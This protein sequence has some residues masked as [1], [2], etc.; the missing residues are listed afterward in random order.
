M[1]ASGTRGGPER[2]NVRSR[3]TPPIETCATRTRTLANPPPVDDGAVQAVRPRQRGGQT[4][5]GSCTRPQDGSLPFGVC[6]RVCV[7]LVYVERDTHTP[8]TL[9]RVLSIGLEAFPG[10]FHGHGRE[11]EM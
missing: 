4:E 2:S 5:R 3:L 11:R 6:A 1:E 8:E 9:P 10:T 7:H